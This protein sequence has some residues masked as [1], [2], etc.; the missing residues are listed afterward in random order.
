[1]SYV[2]IPASQLTRLRDAELVHLEGVYSRHLGGAVLT[3]GDCRLNLIGE[4]FTY[5]PTQGAHVAVWGLLL[6]G[7]VKRLHIHDAAPVGTKHE[8]KPM[9][10]EIGRVGDSIALSVRSE[11]I[12]D[13][14]IVTT[15]DRHSYFAIGEELAQRHYMVVGRIVTLT[16]PTL[17]VEQAVPVALSPVPQHR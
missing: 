16:P 14:Q 10:S 13:D 7:P 3:Q 12:G 9:T 17:L 5:V 6:Q 15:A 8:V 4:P 2:K 11:H 1:M